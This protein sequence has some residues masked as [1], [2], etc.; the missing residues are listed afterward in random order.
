MK[1]VSM[2][3]AMV[4]VLVSASVA[5]AALAVTDATIANAKL[6]VK[7]TTASA[8]E[9]VTLDGQFTVKSDA[10]KNFSFALSNYH[11]SSCVVTVAVG[12]NEATG[13][14]GNC[15]DAGTGAN[16]TGTIHGDAGAVAAHSCLTTDITVGG[17]SVGEAGMISFTG[18]VPAPA[19]L[20]FEFIKV[21]SANHAI[22][23]L[24]NPTNVASPAFS[25][26]GVRVV[27][28]K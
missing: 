28:F 17:A 1:N 10:Q 14:V 15:G 9:K 5:Q 7:G 22:L 20:I 24:C 18:N 8:H 11:P 16:I 25:D 12:A 6:V 27:T 19:G 21:S 2:F 13:V 26:V 23:R 4:A 3:L